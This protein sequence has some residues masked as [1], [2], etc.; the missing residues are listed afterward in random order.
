MQ[1]IELL[2]LEQEVSK[3]NILVEKVMWD[4]LVVGRTI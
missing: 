1:I 4:V 3:K 2:Y